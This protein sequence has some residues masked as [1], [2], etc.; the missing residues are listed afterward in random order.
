[1]LLVDSNVARGCWK[2]GVVTDVVLSDD[3]CVREVSVRTAEGV[4]RR[5]VRKVCLLE[6]SLIP[7]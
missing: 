7:V 2:R 5:D 3:N 1:M 4:M 6:E